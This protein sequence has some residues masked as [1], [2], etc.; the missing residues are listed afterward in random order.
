MASF[1]GVLRCEGGWGV[2]KVD[3]RQK[4]LSIGLSLSRAFPKGRRIASPEA[5]TPCDPEVCYA[6]LQ[7]GRRVPSARR[8]V[9]GRKQRW[10]LLQVAYPGL[11]VPRAPTGMSDAD[12]LDALVLAWAAQETAAGRAPGRFRHT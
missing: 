4:R 12:V 6:E 8:T 1:L 9:L 3:V 11:P 5:K 10:K 2:A 7:G